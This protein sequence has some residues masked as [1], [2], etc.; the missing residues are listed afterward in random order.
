MT[1]ATTQEMSFYLDTYLDKN[2]LLAGI[3]SDVKR[4]NTATKTAD[5]VDFAAQN[6]FSMG[7]RPG[8]ENV[9]VLLTDGSARTGNLGAASQRLRNKVDRTIVLYAKYA[10][11]QEMLYINGFNPSDLKKF[12]DYTTMKNEYMYFLDMLC[13]EYPFYFVS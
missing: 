4:I 11:E 7:D 8:Y 6:C 5:A 2:S 9:V 13:G 1:Y 12:T 3:D 10:N